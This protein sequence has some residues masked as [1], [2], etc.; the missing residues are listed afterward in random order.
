[1]TNL[2]IAAETAETV[3][4]PAAVAKFGNRTCPEC[5]EAFAAGSYQQTFCTKEHKVAF[6]ARAAAEGR[7]I[8]A[9]AKAWR[10]GRNVKGSTP[11]ALALRQV[12]ADA[13]S[14]MSSILDLFIS[15]DREEGRPN[16][17]GYAKTLL[18]QGK[19]IDRQRS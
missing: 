14:E 8:L 13:L 5:G 7:A 19:F 3:S 6:Q 4:Q 18:R 2:T 10:V 12:A 16:P 17:L 1:M 11:E 9:L 15:Q